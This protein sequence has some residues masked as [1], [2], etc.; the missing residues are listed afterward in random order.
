MSDPFRNHVVSISDN[1]GVRVVKICDQAL[2]AS[3]ELVREQ[4]TSI[5]EDSRGVVVDC[6]ELPAS[7]CDVIAPLLY[8]LLLA[9]RRHNPRVEVSV[10]GRPEQTIGTGS[11][12]LMP[13]R[14]ET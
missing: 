2:E 5:V 1:A 8:E 7:A 13:P 10:V 14:F 12:V 11:A 4:L 6:R 9:G 3:I